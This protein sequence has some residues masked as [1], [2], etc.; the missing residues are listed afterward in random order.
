VTSPLASPIA[1]PA[2]E[3]ATAAFAAG[4]T[5]PPPYELSVQHARDGLPA[6]QAAAAVERPAASITDHV[7]SAGPT[8]EVAVRIVRPP[9][10]AAPAAAVVYG[11][12][13][14][15]VFGRSRHA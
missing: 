1:Q 3:P 9:G 5:G 2:L 8:G 11:H 13:G 15:W 14:G 4:L 12:G 7:V 6:L 10:L